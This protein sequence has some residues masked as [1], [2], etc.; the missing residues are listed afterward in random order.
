MDG[1]H[2]QDGRHSGTDGLY[3]RVSMCI[4]FIHTKKT[5]YWI[6]TLVQNVKGLVMCQFLL[7]FKNI[8]LRLAV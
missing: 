7:L 3:S 1:E 8:F 4:S 5:M 2:D 6:K